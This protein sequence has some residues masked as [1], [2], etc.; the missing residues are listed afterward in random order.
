[1]RQGCLCTHT[2]PCDMGW[3]EAEPFVRHQVTYQRVAPCPICR[4]E[5]AD[6]LAR[7]L[8]RES[9]DAR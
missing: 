3:I 1:M 6:R 9:R 8:E 7:R 2:D 5:A 4:P